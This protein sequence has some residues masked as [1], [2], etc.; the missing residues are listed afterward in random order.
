[1]L[2]V[3]GVRLGLP[4][5]L[6]GGPV[7]LLLEPSRSLLFCY[8]KIGSWLWSVVEILRMFVIL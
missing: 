3:H 6:T 8:F 5:Y 2:L 1:M 7:A 4:D